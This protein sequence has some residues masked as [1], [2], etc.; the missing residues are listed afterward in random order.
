MTNGLSKTSRPQVVILDDYERSAKR[1]ADW[2]SINAKAD[3]RVYEQPLIG[4]ALVDAI[5]IAQVLVLVRD[6]TPVTKALLDQL[7][8]LKYLIFTGARNGLLDTTALA[9]RA[10]PVS[11]TEF[12]PSKEATAE[13][14][15]ALLMA[16]MKRFDLVLQTAG[17]LGADSWRPAGGSGANAGEFVMPRLLNGAVLGLI[18]LG[19]IGSKVASVAKVLGMQVKAWSPNMTPD[20]ASSLGVEYTS[21]DSLLTTSDVVSLHLVLAASTRHIMNEQ[22][23]GLM[24]SSAVL[25]NTS[26]SGLVDEQALAQALKRGQIAA[27]AVDVFDVEPVPPRYPL[28][29]APNL[30]STPHLGFVCQPVYEKFWVGVTQALSAWLEGEP[31]PRLYV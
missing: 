5:K 27:A 23:L 30:I 14:T 15:I 31:L 9:A 16:A 4:Q 17:K 25:I 7:P 26:R 12:G 24:K 6:R 29:Q 8:H 10:I 11:H 21:L 20:R 28:T 1:M 22:R 2:T 19:S 3:V 18:G 13:L